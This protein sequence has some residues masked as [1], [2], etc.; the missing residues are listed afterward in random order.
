MGD[1]R[2]PYRHPERSRGI[3][4]IRGET[5]GG[6]NHKR[7]TCSPQAF[8]HRPIYTCG[9]AATFPVEPIE[10]VEPRSLII[11]KGDAPEASPFLIA[12]H[13]PAVLYLRM[14]T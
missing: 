14:D 11:K 6:R 8:G 9:E 1:I 3:F 10:P 2:L 7:E 5:D 12:K 13:T 4:V